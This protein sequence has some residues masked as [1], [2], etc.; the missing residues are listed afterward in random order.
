MKSILKQVEQRQ[1][2]IIEEMGQIGVMRRGSISEQHY[3]ARHARKGGKGASGPYF[4]WQGYDDGK[5]FSQRVPAVQVEQMKEEVEQRRRFEQLCAEYVRLGEV[6]A[7][8]KRQK[9]AA[10]GEAEKEGLKSRS[11][12][13]GKS[14]G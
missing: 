3:P 14:S 4:I 8:R 1:E 12:R 5:H 9:G 13:A 10:S 2:A 11:N 6:L 7:E